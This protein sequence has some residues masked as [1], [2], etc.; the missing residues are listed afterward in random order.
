MTDITS[1][2]GGL[3][4]EFVLLLFLQVHRETDQ[5][6]EASGVQLAQTNSGLFHFRRSTFSSQFKA[7]VGST[8]AKTDA[9][10]VNLNLDGVTIT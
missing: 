5:F 7:K 2:S 10:R 4:S 9:L 3:H 8:L 6:F 1:T